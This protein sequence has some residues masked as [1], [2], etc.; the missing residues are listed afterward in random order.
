ML[1]PS[2][3]V[4]KIINRIVWVTQRSIEAEEN[5][6][7]KKEERKE[8]IKKNNSLVSNIQKVR[9]ISLWIFI[10]PFISINVCLLIITKFHQLL[11]PGVPIHSSMFPYLDGGVSISR[12][13][14]NY[15]LYLIF[16]PAMFL[17]SILLIQYWLITKK[18]INNLERNHKYLKKIIFFGITSAVFLTIHSIF[19]GIKI[20]NDL[21]KLLRRFVLL[22]FILFEL[23]AQAYLVAIYLQLGKKINKHI[24]KKILQVKKNLVTVLIMA[25][26][27]ALP[28]LP[29]DNFKFLKHALEWNLFLGLIIFY[30]LTYFMWKK[31]SL[32]LLSNPTTP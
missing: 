2:N 30:L 14:R 28:F 17:T 22:S 15:P 29:F 19:L 11:A 31:N 23:I 1:Y 32:K 5:R 25:S 21:Y 8:K 4:N 26:V 20:D 6:V 3:N 18:I 27:V 9:S 16:K 10:I 12:V 24:N 7:L 13:V